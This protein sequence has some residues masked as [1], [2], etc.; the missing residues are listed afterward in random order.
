MFN[1]Q[2]LQ[3]E[4][5]VFR[6]PG[7]LIAFALA[8]F[9]VIG[10]G[11]VPAFGVR[12]SCPGACPVAP[13]A[14]DGSKVADK[15]WFVHRDLG[16]EGS[17][18]V[19]LTEMAGTIT[20]PPPDHDEIVPGLVPWAKT[21]IMLKDGTEQ[22]SAY[23]AV[24]MTGE[25][26][27]RMQYDY[28]HDIAGSPGQ[29]A[30]DAPRWLRLTRDGDEVTGY[31]SADGEQ[32]EEIGTAMLDGLPDTVQVGLFAASPGDLSLDPVGLGGVVESVRFTQAGGTFDHIGLEGAG[33]GK[34][35]SEAVGE[36]N[37]TDWEKDHNPSGSTETDGSITVSGTGD[38]GP[39]SDEGVR[40]LP[41]LLLGLPVGLV[42]MVMAA[43]RWG[44]RTSAAEPRRTLAARAAVLT[45]ASF[46]AGLVGVG[47]VVLAGSAVLRAHGNPVPHLTLLTGTQVIVGL[48]AVTALCAA[49][50]YYLGAL[51]RRGW[52]AI[53]AGLL[54]TAIPYVV[55]T[56][57]FLPDEVNRW[58]LRLT[59]AS[60]FAIQQTGVE[61]SQV[62]AH[63]APS[64]G[65]FPLP[66]WAGLAVLCGYL[67]AVAWWATARRPS[68]GADPWR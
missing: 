28:E 68:A 3:R 24:M 65:Y 43:A 25:H 37:H 6:R 58:I 66:A 4:W 47:V 62:V 18:T 5:A 30:P 57:P 60:A 42:V 52:A 54:L 12:S 39:L 59:P 9:A 41:L 40:L 22:G 64:N 49:F 27:V 45:A 7:R 50:A 36:M 55:A 35:Q 67:V 17:I 48:A 13:T 51:L 8:V 20:Y 63:Y 33:D 44:A 32:W 14:A 15:F 31:E 16:P 11:L 38:I 23:A 10:L 26:G 1:R 53:L 2:L 34:W 21:G 19:R 56:T 61:Y 29:V 46:L